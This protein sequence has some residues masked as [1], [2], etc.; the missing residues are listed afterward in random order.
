MLPPEEKTYDT[1]NDLFASV[2]QFAHTQGYTIT[3]RNSTDKGCKVWL[4]CSRGGPTR[5]VAE[6]NRQRKGVKK[7]GLCH[8]SVNESKHNHPAA[9]DIAGHAAARRMTE[10][11]KK[12]VRTGINA[13][14]APRDVFTG[15][16]LNDK[17]I[18][19][20]S[21]TIYNQRAKRSLAGVNRFER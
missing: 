2:K 17:D 21:R 4:K 11:Q 20:H 10:E 14:S 13:G 9:L 5:Q 18:L 19:Y 15:S 7:E 6:A 1:Y 8:L 3:T 16:R 12:V